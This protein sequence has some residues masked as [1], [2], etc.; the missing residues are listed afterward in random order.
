MVAMNQINMVANHVTPRP[1][2]GTV[3]EVTQCNMTVQHEHGASA[4]V[5]LWASDKFWGCLPILAR[6]VRWP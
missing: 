3:K 6:D 4:P 1:L 5:R 2:H